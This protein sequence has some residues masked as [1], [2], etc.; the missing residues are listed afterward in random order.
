LLKL[1]PTKARLIKQD[2]TV[3]VVGVAELKIGD[4]LQVLNGD[5]VPTDGKILF[6]S[7]LID[8][9]SITGES[10]PVEKK[11][12]DFVFG[13]TING[14][15]S[16]TMLVTKNSEDTVIAKIIK[17]VGQAQTNISKTASFIKR[18]E[19]KYVTAVLLIAPL[20]YLAGV[21]L[22]L[23]T[24]SLSFYKTMILLIVASPCALAA[25]DVPATLS[26]ISN[27]AKRGVLFKGGSYLSN[28]SDLKVVAFDKTGT[29]TQGKPVLTDFY[30]DASI[31]KTQ[32]KE[33]ENIIF[34]M[35]NQSN[36]PIAGAVIEYFNKAK[37]L[38][39]KVE[40]IIG[41]G[42]EAS[43][44][45]N[46]YRL[47]KPHF[48]HGLQQDL[49]DKTIEFEKN[50]K[51][52]VHFTCNEKVVALI[53]VQDIPKE[54]SKESVD[55]FNQQGVHTVMLSGDAVL[56][57]QAIGKKLGI[58]Q[59]IANILP[60]DK[61]EIIKDL[62]K[63]YGTVAMIGDGVND[64]PALVAADIGVAMGSGTDIAIDAADAVLMQSDLLKFAYAHKLAKKLR[65]IVWQNIIFSMGVVG[66]LVLINVFQAINMSFAVIMH[67]G[68]TLMVILN[69]LRLLRKV[70]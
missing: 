15:H 56:T 24:S 7:S 40:N 43:Y 6:G 18:F 38:N 68:S 9:S 17:M 1:N 13:S 12:G 26:S 5:Q 37:T 47:V 69:G 22:F 36:H 34:S 62:K 49:K 11:E 61:A 44:K 23:W 65:R 27:L 29:L 16:F 70:K 30:I 48:N 42:L 54:S 45:G 46:I 57:A 51:T 41:V 59:V 66:A 53:A 67:E 4:R 21:Y 10:M 64:A 58:N 31:D 35:E 2:G 8:E 28:I 3:V 20:F 39:L 60:Q 14:N 55:Y 50:A 33:F 32:R 52:V 25:T 19:P 63:E